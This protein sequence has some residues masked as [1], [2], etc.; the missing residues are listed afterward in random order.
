METRRKL[1]KVGGSVM[2]PI[3]PEILEEL[4]LE[5]GSEVKITSGD[6]Q[7]RVEPAVRRP[8]PEVAEFM[9]RFMGRYDRALRNLADG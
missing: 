2:L 8:S 1:S 5:T 7:I 3:P 4:A 9:R 6:E